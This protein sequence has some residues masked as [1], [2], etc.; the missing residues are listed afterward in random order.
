MMVSKHMILGDTGGSRTSGSDKIGE[1]RDDDRRRRSAG[2]V[3][4][5][6]EDHDDK[7][8]VDGYTI[9]RAL[10]QEAWCATFKRKTVQVTDGAV[11]VRVAS[12]KYRSQHKS[13][14]VSMN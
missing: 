5:T 2:Q 10:R 11:C 4:K 7:E 14:R 13:M 1:P 9:S 8:A 12:R 3:R 6:R